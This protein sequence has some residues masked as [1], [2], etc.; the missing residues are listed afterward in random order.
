MAEGTGGS[1]PWATA[2][3]RLEGSYAGYLAD[4]SLAWERTEGERPRVPVA[5]GRQARYA[6]IGSSMHSLS[7]NLPPNLLAALVERMVGGWTPEAA[8]GYALQIPDEY[9]RTAAVC[10]LVKLV[11]T[12]MS[13]GLLSVVE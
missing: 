3:Y 6:L 8:L 4:V 10:H 12:E 1:L 9:Q 11:P 7:A 2:R 5:V 13:D